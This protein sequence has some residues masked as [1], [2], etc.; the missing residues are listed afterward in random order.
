LNQ[1][2]NLNSSTTVRGGLLF[3]KE[4]AII[5]NQAFNFANNGILKINRTPVIS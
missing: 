4:N 2:F 5:E 1:L 3:G